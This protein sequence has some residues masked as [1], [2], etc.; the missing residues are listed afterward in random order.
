MM[1][2]DNY[3][4]HFGVRRIRALLLG[5][6][7]VYLAAVVDAFRHHSGH[8]SSGGLTA[9][10]PRRPIVVVRPVGLGASLTVRL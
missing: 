10:A 8:L 3:R 1:A 2:H 4:K 9:S 6:A 7:A 5:T